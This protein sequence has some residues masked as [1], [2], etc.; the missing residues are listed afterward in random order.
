MLN[1]GRDRQ[2]KFG[3]SPFSPH[4]LQPPFA[5]QKANIAMAPRGSRDAAEHGTRRPLIAGVRKG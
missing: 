2:A 1:G 5:G 4:R 3:Q